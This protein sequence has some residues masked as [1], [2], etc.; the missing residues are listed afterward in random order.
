MKGI[1]EMFNADDFFDIANHGVEAVVCL[2][3]QVSITVFGSQQGGNVLREAMQPPQN[4]LSS[5]LTWVSEGGVPASILAS[6]S[7]ISW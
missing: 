3:V 2:I 5:F 4:N 7:A 1:D 6:R